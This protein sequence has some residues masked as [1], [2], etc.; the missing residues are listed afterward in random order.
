MLVEDYLSKEYKERQRHIDLNEPCLER[1]G[2]STAHRGVLAEYLNS[3]I[4]SSP[5]D[6]CHACNNDKC[7]N[8]KHLYWGTRRENVQDAINNGTFIN[9]WQSTVKKYGYEEA[10]RMNARGDKAASGRGNK[11]KPKSEEHKKKIAE[12]VRQKHIGKNK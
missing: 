1:G 12:S 8:P 6:L 3:P 11:G 9:P 5:A 4:Y 10:C 7:S 2:N